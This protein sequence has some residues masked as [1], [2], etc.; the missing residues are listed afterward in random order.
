MLLQ[1][2]IV[3]RSYANSC[4]SSV[5]ASVSCHISLFF[6]FFF[7]WFI[8]VHYLGIHLLT[9]LP[10]L[11]TLNPL[12]GLPL[13]RDIAAI[14]GSAECLPLIREWLWNCKSTHSNNECGGDHPPKARLP[15]RILD[16]EEEPPRLV[17][18]AAIASV[19]DQRANYVA[20]SHCWGSEGMMTTGP[21]KTLLSNLARHLAVGVP[22]ES[23]PQTFGDAIVVSKYL[24]YLWIDSLC[25]IQDH[26]RDWQRESGHMA[27][28][29][30]NADLVLGATSAANGSCGILGSRRH[31]YHVQGTLRVDSPPQRQ[32]QQQQEEEGKEGDGAPPWTA[33]YRSALPHN[34]WLSNQEAYRPADEGP[35]E[36]RGW[37]YQER[38]MARRYVS[39][40]KRELCWE[41]TA[42]LD[43]E[44]CSVPTDSNRDHLEETLTVRT[45]MLPP[46]KYN[47]R[48][49]LAQNLAPEALRS[50]WRHNTVEPYCRRELSR[51]S[52]RLAAISAS[53]ARFAERLRGDRY[54]AGIWGEDLANGIGLC[55]Y[56]IAAE[57][58]PNTLA[59]RVG[60][61]ALSWSW[62]SVTGAITHARRNKWKLDLKSSPRIGSVDYFVAAENV[63][64][65]PSRASISVYGKVMHDVKL[66]QRAP[67]DDGG[68]FQLH[69]PGT[70][71]VLAL[72]VDT[73]I[74]TIEL[75]GGEGSQDR[76]VIITSARRKREPEQP[77]PRR[78]DATTATTATSS[79][80]DGRGADQKVFEG[81]ACLALA[82]P[83]ALLLG[84]V[85]LR[86]RKYERLGFC[87]LDCEGAQCSA[88]EK[89]EVQDL[90]LV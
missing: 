16:I 76:S 19:A 61:G 33:C 49:K 12:P 23:L 10:T 90:L 83:S 86:P 29:Y 74:E 21:P 64:G 69:L 18:P 25:I 1:V 32:Q 53:A 34:P 48:R 36:T 28:V 80:Q 41:C 55:W 88:W 89:I 68:R 13:R 63:F 26:H 82:E 57:S 65:S 50:A 6:V 14:R 58:E 35:L 8:R 75:C 85:S 59:A 40:G 42:T 39:F 54:L 15:T 24:G 44:C 9:R 5:F 30:G 87:I 78:E 20:L 81:L 45:Q 79:T 2:G 62:A 47:L 37:A 66:T 73:E 72:F 43:C 70:G 51:P 52:D 71:K 56:S 67:S 38:I 77:L 11:D 60:E 22:P 84:L 3:R 17:E 27:D 31:D 46:R 7:G 4:S